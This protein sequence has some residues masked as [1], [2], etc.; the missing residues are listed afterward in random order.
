MTLIF[1]DAWLGIFAMADPFC[2]PNNLR[3]LHAGP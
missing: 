3:D 2:D 1:L